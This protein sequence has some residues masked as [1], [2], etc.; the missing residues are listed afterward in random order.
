[1]KVLWFTP[2]KPANVSV[3]RSRIVDHLRDRGFDVTIR[4]TI[5]ATVLEGFRDGG[6]YDVIVGTT[7]AGAVAA[8]TV[9]TVHRRPLV[10]DHVDPISQFEATHPP[11]LAAIVKNLEAVAFRLADHVLYVYPEEAV[12]VESR[13][14]AATRTD[15]G[16][17][18]EKFA[19]PPASVVERARDA[20]RKAGVSGNMAIY[21]GGLEPIYHVETM[22]AA[23]DHLSDWTLVV[24]GTGSL[25]RTVEAAA[26]ERDD[27]VFPGTVPH[28]DVPGYLHCA[29][30][31]LCL[32]D[33]AH[34][35]K[36][37]EYGAAGLPTVQLNGA[38][39]QRFDGYVEFC[40]NDPPDVAA[41]IERASLNGYDDQFQSYV[42]QY[43]WSA[44]ADDYEQAFR[45]V[46]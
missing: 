3:G 26:R 23:F 30:A 2:N 45:C 24:L 36:A 22:L 16:L 5:P 31:G 33:D 6:S 46:T 8:T 37:L 39:R 9:A 29:D 14:E 13:T 40:E 41:A 32:V 27:V 42:R 12:R 7:R 21:V 19:D 17:D 38:A 44:I 4:T 43:D 20:L 1:M 25:E 10:V 28:E 18:F 15:L 11:W 34:T 35:L